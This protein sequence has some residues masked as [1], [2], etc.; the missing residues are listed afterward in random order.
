[1][2]K[3]HRV[4]REMLAFAR[5][6]VGLEF[7]TKRQMDDY[8][9]E[10]DVRRDTKMEVKPEAKK[11]PEGKEPAKKEPKKHDFSP[12]SYFKSNPKHKD[13]VDA[14]KE[15]LKKFKD[16][17]Q[18]KGDKEKEGEVA[19]EALKKEIEKAK[20]DHGLEQGKYNDLPQDVQDGFAAKWKPINE[21]YYPKEEDELSTKIKEHRS[22]LNKIFKDAGIEVGSSYESLSPSEYEEKIGNIHKSHHVKRI[23]DEI[24]KSP[25]IGKTD[26]VK[27]G[28]FL[29]ISGN[30][31]LIVKVQKVTPSGQ[32]H[33]TNT[34]TGS[35]GTY[36][37][38][39]WNAL[40]DNHDLFS[41]KEDLADEAADYVKQE[42]G[43]KPE[44]KSASFMA[45]RLLSMAKDLMGS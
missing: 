24:K 28:D 21:K 14:A 7:D 45:S 11:Q 36:T 16:V 6:L 4:A 12:E 8:K 13:A 10:H 30:G 37:K 41:V 26:T 9:R 43:S 20:K 27:P 31:T 22:K 32:I 40:F 33:Y 29:A 35:E 2:T 42:F 18:K 39:Q 5:E 34:F 15:E 44:Q 19:V 3:N 38:K 23:S 1:M 25:K 17:W